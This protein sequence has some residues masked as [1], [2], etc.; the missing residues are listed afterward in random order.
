M[1]TQDENRAKW[2]AHVESLR[3]MDCRAVDPKLLLE[4]ERAIRRCPYPS[5]SDAIMQIN[6]GWICGRDYDLCLAALLQAD[7]LEPSGFGV[8]RIDR[9]KLPQIEV[10]NLLADAIGPLPL[11]LRRSSPRLRLSLRRSSGVCFDKGYA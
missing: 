6:G 5:V 9:R 1:T 2:K 11:R 3:T 10:E 4:V 7:C 8:F